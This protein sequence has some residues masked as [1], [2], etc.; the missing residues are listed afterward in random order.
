MCHDRN[1]RDSS[2]T[3][4]VKFGAQAQGYECKKTDGKT[5]VPYFR[6]SWSK[7]KHRLHQLISY[8]FCWLVDTS[9][10]KSEPNKNQDFIIG[11]VCEESDIITNFKTF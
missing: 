2:N 9:L 7:R 11:H 1:S 8:S 10:E 5:T 3:G 4:A 6:H